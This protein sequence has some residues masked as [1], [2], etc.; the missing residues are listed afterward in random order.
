MPAD[1][2]SAHVAVG[3]IQ[4]RNGE[5]L[6]SRRHDNVHQGG[7]WEFPGGK[8]EPGESI[9]DALSR[10]LRVELG[11][12]VQN[13]IPL[14]K[15]KHNYTDLNVLLDAWRVIGYV[16]KPSGLEGQSIAW[17]M[18]D[19]L[20]KYPFPAANLPIISASR[21]P[22]YYAILEDD[23]GDPIVLRD[24][25][26]RLIERGVDLIRVRAKSLS[27]SKYAELAAWACNFAA[28][29]GAKIL[30]NGEPELASKVGAAGIHWDS[31]KLMAAKSRPMTGFDWVV[32][33]C[34]NANELK[35]AQ[36]LGMDFVVLGPI[37]KTD[38]H[39]GARSIGWFTFEQLVADTRI[40]VYALGGL[41][42]SDL[43][44]IRLIGGQGVAG[45]SAFL[46]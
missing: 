40:P 22:N 41:R 46:A 9:W 16:G 5:I 14:I 36:R 7:L 10:E 37:L 25:F 33:S 19:Q 2:K 24:R 26:A 32:A 18:S 43:T 6:I 35:Q 11:V 45:I 8:V 15:I 12:T 42:C 20:E 31:E 3:V 28:K 13:A 44:R 38:S 1:S 30:L 34:H 27:A 17:V 4:N 23:R 29:S 39:P 21:L